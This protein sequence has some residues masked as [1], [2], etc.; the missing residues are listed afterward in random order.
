[1][2]IRLDQVRGWLNR[3]DDPEFWERVRDVCGLYLSPPERAL[4][5]SV[6]EKTSIQAKQR[7]HPDQVPAPGRPRRRE[8]E[9]RRRS[10]SLAE[11]SDAGVIPYL[12][13]GVIP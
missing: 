10:N 8:F 13:A 4:V 11:R 12:G 9:C 1:M 6:D 7:R 5:L 2:D 3:R